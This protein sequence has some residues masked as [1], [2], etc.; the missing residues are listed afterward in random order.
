[1]YI[2]SD[3]RES[4]HQVYQEMDEDKKME[5]SDEIYRKLLE[6]KEKDSNS[7]IR[8]YQTSQGWTVVSVLD[9]SAGKRGLSIITANIVAISIVS[10]I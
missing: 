5:I 2:S 9:L 3:Q 10:T 4:V 7:Y 1:M 8:E 6:K